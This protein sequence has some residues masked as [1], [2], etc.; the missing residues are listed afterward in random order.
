MLMAACAQEKPHEHTKVT[1]KFSLQEFK[2]E[3]K[4]HITE[5]STSLKGK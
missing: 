4:Y 2:Y 3:K 5:D 1:T